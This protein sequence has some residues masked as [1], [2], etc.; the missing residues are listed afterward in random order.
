M[1]ANLDKKDAISASAGATKKGIVV[2]EGFGLVIREG[3]EKRGVLAA[4]GQAVRLDLETGTILGGF[5]QRV[6]VFLQEREAFSLERFN[7][8]LAFINSHAPGKPEETGFELRLNLLEIIDYLGTKKDI[9]KVWT[10]LLKGDKKVRDSKENWEENWEVVLVFDFI[11][12]FGGRQAVNK[13]DFENSEKMKTI[14]M[15]AKEFRDNRCFSQK[16]IEALKKLGWI[17]NLTNEKEQALMGEN[18]PERWNQPGYMDRLFERFLFGH[19]V[20]LV[21]V[22]AFLLRQFYQRAVRER[23]I[24]LAGTDKVSPKEGSLELTSRQGG[25]ILPQRFLEL[26]DPVEDTNEES[27]LVVF[28]RSQKESGL[29]DREVTAAD[30]WQAIRAV[31]QAFYLGYEG[32]VLARGGDSSPITTVLDDEAINNARGLWGWPLFEAMSRNPD[33]V[34]VLYE[35]FSSNSPESLLERL[36]NFKKTN[37]QNRNLADLIAAAAVMIEKI[38]ILDPQGMRKTDRRSFAL[39]PQKWGRRLEELSLGEGKI[40]F[41]GD[42]CLGTLPSTRLG[43]CS[44]FAKTADRDGF[45]PPPLR[46]IGAQKP[47]RTESILEEKGDGGY[48]WRDWVYVFMSRLELARPGLR[49][50]PGLVVV[51]SK[52]EQELPVFISDSGTFMPFEN[53]VKDSETG[54]F[55]YRRA[56][57]E[58]MAKILKI[59]RKLKDERGRGLVSVEPVSDTL[60]AAVNFCKQELHRTL[61]FGGIEVE[62]EK[63]AG[64]I[65]WTPPLEALLQAY[66]SA[67]NKEKESLNRSDKATMESLLQM[68]RCLQDPRCWGQALDLENPEVKER[69]RTLMGLAE[70]LRYTK[71]LEALVKDLFEFLGK[72]GPVGP[73]VYELPPGKLIELIERHQ[74]AE[75]VPSLFYMRLM[76]VLIAL[77]LLAIRRAVEMEVTSVKEGIRKM[78]PGGDYFLGL[79]GTVGRMLGVGDDFF[80]KFDIGS[81]DESGK[82]NPREAARILTGFIKDMGFSEMLMEAVSWMIVSGAMEN[83]EALLESQLFREFFAEALTWAQARQTPFNE[84]MILAFAR[85][86]ETDRPIESD[87]AVPIIPINQS[88]VTTDRF[89]W[90]GFNHTQIA[91]FFRP[92]DQDKPEDM[93]MICRAFGG[94]FILQGATEGKKTRSVKV[95]GIKGFGANTQVLVTKRDASTGEEF[96]AWAYLEDVKKDLRVISLEFVDADPNA[97]RRDGEKMHQGVRVCFDLEKGLYLAAGEWK[98][99]FA[100]EWVFNPAPNG[101]PSRIELRMGTPDSISPEDDFYLLENFDRHGRPVFNRKRIGDVFPDLGEKGLQEVGQDMMVKPPELPFLIVRTD[102]EMSP[103]ELMEIFLK[104]RWAMAFSL[105]MGFGEYGRGGDPSVRGSPLLYQANAVSA[106]EFSPLARRLLESMRVLQRIA[107][108]RKAFAAVLSE[109]VKG[110]YVNRETAITV[111]SGLIEKAAAGEVWGEDLRII[112][113]FLEQISDADFALAAKSPEIRALLIEK[114]NTR[115]E[116][117]SSPEKLKEIDEKIKEERQRFQEQ[118][119]VRIH[120]NFWQKFLNLKLPNGIPLVGGAAVG[121]LL[122]TAFSNTILDSIVIGFLRLGGVGSTPGFLYP[123]GILW[124]LGSY[125]F[126]NIRKDA[127]VAKLVFST[128]ISFESLDLIWGDFMKKLNLERF[129]N[130]PKE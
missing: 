108:L 16:S 89:C 44:D 22:R 112:L 6:R 42:V 88:D 92:L 1:M 81:G 101:R 51:T 127:L 57:Y 114:Y 87:E 46:G 5:A 82:N 70:D 11:L 24:E 12:E 91:N 119:A 32:N 9:Q 39:F 27:P 97:K 33:L 60:E 49:K 10:E 100:G 118:Q 30:Y 102:L 90:T 28:L 58:Q 116:G 67:T 66:E 62:I 56:V 79:S 71:N 48:D 52:G 26:F 128:P 21:D 64:E 123:V 54:E 76:N 73:R 37:Q 36:E 18:K 126:F 103:Q 75:I 63:N 130:V 99:S 13:I 110:E 15:A 85:N 25:E 74:G 23:L 55:I 72:G 3:K 65:Y 105:Q 35:L 104:E 43:L 29:G 80:Q 68:R 17:R 98:R 45:V 78:S 69:I 122:A 31:F 113:D 117:R 14:L 96:K 124:M 109:E 50:R 40:N 111:I 19:S 84:M 59:H 83:F 115:R 2:E 120:L 129:I 4:K 38:L 7:E 107:V 94:V 95:Y 8:V 93:E 121:P 86:A 41:L 20:P 77:D 61:R 47:L 34:K 125:W 53:F 106:T